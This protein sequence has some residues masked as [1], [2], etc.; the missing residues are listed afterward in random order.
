MVSND[1]P[2]EDT[3]CGTRVCELGICT[4]N[5]VA[6]EG[7]PAGLPDIPG[8]CKITQCNGKGTVETVDATTTDAYDYGNPCIKPDCSAGSVVMLTY[9]S[10]GMACDLDG[11]PGKCDGTGR[12]VECIPGDCGANA[13]CQDGKCVP[14]TCTDGTKDGAETDVDCGGPCAPCGADKAC[15]FSFDCASKKCSGSP[16]LCQSPTCVD[17]FE[18]GDETDADCGGSC[19]PTKTCPDGQ[20][21]L[22]HA[23]CASA[24]CE[25]GVCKTKP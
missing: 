5:N 11:M 15:S 19:A 7:T 8:D 6:V 22:H 12:C 10:A 2:G 3:V 18:N 16:K 25:S 9:E 17:G 20:K 13:L 1:C 14:T 4:W 23:D 21:C 24:Y